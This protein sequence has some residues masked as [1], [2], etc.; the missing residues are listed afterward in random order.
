[1]RGIADLFVEDYRARG[2]LLWDT[3]LRVLSAS[4]IVPDAATAS[5]IKNFLLQRITSEWQ[6]LQTQ[7]ENEVEAIQCSAE[8]LVGRLGNAHE[9]FRDGLFARVDLRLRELAGQQGAGST[10]VVQN[11]S[12]RSDRCGSIR[13]LKHRDR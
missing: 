12:F 4:G 3:T 6:Q 11:F 2:E 10:H 5:D 9:T 8:G 1:M 7:L 13:K